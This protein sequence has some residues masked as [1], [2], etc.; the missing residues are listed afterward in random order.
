MGQFWDSDKRMTAREKGPRFQVRWKKRKYHSV[1]QGRRLRTEQ[2]QRETAELR[3]GMKQTVLS[4]T[5]QIVEMSILHQQY[6]LESSPPPA[7]LCRLPSL[8]HSP[9]LFSF[10]FTSVLRSQKPGCS[11]LAHKTNTDIRKLLVVCPPIYSYP[12]EL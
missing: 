10:H 2:S 7:P 9:S 12:F 3:E 4:S 5:T 6:R 11:T 1:L 8:S